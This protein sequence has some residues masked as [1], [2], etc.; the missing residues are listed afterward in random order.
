MFHRINDAVV[1][2]YVW[3]RALF[4]TKVVPARGL[5]MLEYALMAL[6]VMAV[7]G[8][9]ITF[10]PEFITNL[11]RDVSNDNTTDIPTGS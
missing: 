8:A 6:V 4:A 7:F 9:M 10:F 3:L 2:L 5:G 11:F 1:S